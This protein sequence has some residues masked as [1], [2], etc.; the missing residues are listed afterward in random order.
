MLLGLALGCGPVDTE[1]DDSVGPQLEAGRDLVD[2]GSVYANTTAVQWL[3]LKNTGDAALELGTAS[4]LGGGEYFLVDDLNGTVLIPGDEKGLRI[5][6]NAPD[7]KTPFHTVVAIPSND[8]DGD[9]WVDIDATPLPNAI[10]M[11]PP[12]LDFGENALSCTATQSGTVKNTG[13]TPVSIGSLVAD[14]PG[15]RVDVRTDTNGDLPWE[16]QPGESKTFDVSFTPSDMGLYDGSVSMVDPSGVTLVEEYMIGQG[17]DHVHYTDQFTVD[18]GALDIMI[19]VQLPTGTFPLATDPQPLIDAFPDFLSALD[20]RGIEYQIAVL[21][22]DDGCIANGTPFMD[23]TM[24]REDQMDMLDDMLDVAPG[25]GITHGLN[26]VDYAVKSTNTQPGG[27][28]E[29]LFRDDAKLAIIGYTYVGYN[30]PRSGWLETVN[31]VQKIK[32]HPEDVTYYGVLEDIRAVRGASCGYGSGSLW[33]EAIDYTGGIWSRICDDPYSGFMDI[34]AAVGGAQ[35]DF[36][37]THTPDPTTIT[38]TI[39]GAAYTNFTYDAPTNSVV[40]GD[41]TYGKE[42]LVNYDAAAS[43][44]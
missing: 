38:V 37:L 34:A 10:Q 42:I 19:P 26:L 32:E 23:W 30:H 3:K 28:N 25:V 41:T 39:G 16:L 22:S 29:F 31:Q 9:L 17:S 12:I 14:G 4:F 6:F 8:P 40:L 15:F 1:V 24:K 44:E 21:A 2:F 36:V 18:G 35:T 11:D 5:R 20:A 13:E 43:C 7:E 33:M 27:C